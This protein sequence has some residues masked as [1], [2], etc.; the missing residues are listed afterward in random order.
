MATSSSTSTSPFRIGRRISSE[1][2]M[3]FELV[4]GFDHVD[5]IG[6]GPWENYP[7]RRHGAVLGRWSCPIAEMSV[8]Y[9]RPQE[10]GTR[11]NVTWLEIA[12]PAGHVQIIP[13]GPAHINVSRYNIADLES[14][15]HWWELTPRDTTVVHVDAAHRGT[16]TGRL[17]P[18]TAAEFRIVDREHTWRW[19][20]HLV[21]VT[22]ESSHNGATVRSQAVGP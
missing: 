4:A 5:W 10:N 9:L 16:G 11:G 2:E 15:G 1:S 8:P 7:D 19:R 13:E 6:L 21:S 12:G 22:R 17:G 18:D 20:L 3:T 14:A